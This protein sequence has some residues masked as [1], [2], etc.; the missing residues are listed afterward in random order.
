MNRRRTAVA[1]LA[2]YSLA[3]GPSS[4]AAQEPQE[5]GWSF[6][7]ELTT[8]LSQ[9]NSEALTFGLGALVRNVWGANTLRIEGGGLRTEST[10]TTRRAVGD[11]SDFEVQSEERTDKTAES[12]FARTRYDRSISEHFFTFAG[13]DWLRNTFAGIDSRFL[14]AAGA[15]NTW[16]ERE[17]VRFKTD[18]AVTYTFQSDVVQNPFTKSNF[19]G[20]RASWEYWNQLTESTELESTLVG[21]LN[22]DDSDDVRVDFRNALAVAINESLALKPSLQLLW[23]NAPALAEVALFAP[24]GEPLDEVVRVPLEELDAFFRLALVVKL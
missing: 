8:V 14:M 9:G 18:Y 12:Y 23:R 11:L 19:P 7:G 16:V 20:V 17:R 15:G 2:A 21:D 10:I 5:Q 3:T 6:T 13:L 1:A 22:L 4:A 24:D